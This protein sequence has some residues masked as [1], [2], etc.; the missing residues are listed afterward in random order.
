MPYTRVHLVNQ[1]SDRLAARLYAEVPGNVSGIRRFPALPETVP[2]R[3]QWLFCSCLCLMVTGRFGEQ[4]E[5]VSWE[6]G[7]Q[8][9]HCRCSSQ[10]PLQQ[11]CLFSH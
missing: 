6:M 1:Y 10:A 4:D 7:W 2:W 11:T 3:E 5:I 8:E 9:L